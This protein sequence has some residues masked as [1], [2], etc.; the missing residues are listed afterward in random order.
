MITVLFM[1]VTMMPLFFPN[2]MDLNKLAQ[3]IIAVC[4]F[5]GAYMAE[6]VRGG[7]QSIPLGQFDASKSV[8]LGYWHT[9]FLVILPQALKAMIQ[10]GRAHV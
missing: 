8:G 1:S 3:V 9:M 5:A 6:T 10:I 7:L 2:T 4:I